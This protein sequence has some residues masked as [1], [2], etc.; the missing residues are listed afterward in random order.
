MKA[1]NTI[2]LSG[3]F[4]IMIASNAS[5]GVLPKDILAIRDAFDKVGATSCSQALAE[6]LHFL[7]KGRSISNN[8][9]WATSDTNKKP[10]SIDFLISGNTSDY[11]TH[12]R[13]LK[14]VSPA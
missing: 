1:A 10:I 3:F 5:A 7:A 4:A 12:T 13:Q 14:T 6:T 9:Q 11:S 8:R 2:F